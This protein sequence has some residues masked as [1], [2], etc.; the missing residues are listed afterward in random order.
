MPETDYQMTQT[1]FNPIEDVELFLLNTDWV[2][3]RIGINEILVGIKGK[4]CEYNVTLHWNDAQNILHFAFAFSVGLSKENLPPHREAPLLKLVCLLNESMGLGHY[5]LWHEENSIV[6]RYGQV[7]FS[8]MSDDAYFAYIFQMAI[9]TCERHYSA[10][11][12][13]LWAGQSPS[14]AIKNILFETAGMA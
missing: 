8:D 2:S 7:F 10:F 13:V 9:A 12:F 5:D 14:D 1:A 4:Y 11:Q 6:W 3:E